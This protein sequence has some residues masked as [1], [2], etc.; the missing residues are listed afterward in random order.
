MW[1]ATTLA[2]SLAIVGAAFAFGLRSPDPT[3]AD[4][5][6]VHAV[7][8]ATL[9]AAADADTALVALEEALNAALD[10]ARR[11]SG[12]TLAGEASPAPSFTAAANLLLAATPTVDDANDEVTRLAGMVRSAFPNVP[13]PHLPVDAG[14]LEGIAAQLRASASAADE[15]VERR[16]IT[17]AT[18]EALG[19]AV[20]ALDEDRLREAAGAL[21]EARSLLAEVRSWDAEFAT[22]PVWTDTTAALI[23]AAEQL[24]HAAE[25]GDEAAAEAAAEAYRVAAEDG[26]QA[27]LA[28]GIAL[29]EGASGVAAA[30]LQRLTEALRE[31]AGSRAAVASVLHLAASLAR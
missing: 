1:R 31:V 29:A 30:P 12:G 6:R 2:G 14:E 4:P 8:S 25:R 20:A 7:R 13:P 3:V 11:G 16:R 21:A 24:T 19:R 27:D 26:H 9:S 22:L 10:E 15:F 23:D 18:I 5:T 17:T 28:L